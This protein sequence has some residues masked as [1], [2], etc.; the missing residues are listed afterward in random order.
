MIKVTNK[1]EVLDAVQWHKSGDHPL[2]GDVSAGKEGHV[3]KHF[4]DP[5]IDGNAACH[6]KRVM[7]EHGWLNVPSHYKNPNYPNGTLVCPGDWIIKNVIG[8][9]FVC[10]KR[11]FKNTYTKIKNWPMPTIENCMPPLVRVLSVARAVDVL[12]AYVKHQSALNGKHAITSKVGHAALL[13]V[14]VANHLLLDWREDTTAEDTE[15]KQGQAKWLV[16]WANH[17]AI[18]MLAA[19]MDIPI[20]VRQGQP[21]YEEWA[22]MTDMEKKKLAEAGFT[23]KDLVSDE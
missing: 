20:R 17:C 7:I 8:D 10:K 3:V 11:E 6:C 9:F 5:K 19:D 4:S 18:R 21:S 22:Y 14:E 13:S 23:K 16:I 12:R 15:W 2:D 1:N